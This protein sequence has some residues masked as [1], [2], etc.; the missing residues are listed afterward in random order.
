MVVQLA[1]RP[2]DR[3]CSAHRPGGLCQLGHRTRDND[4][5]PLVSG[6]RLPPEQPLL[7][8]AAGKCHSAPGSLG[9]VPPYPASDSPGVGMLVDHKLTA[10]VRGSVTRCNARPAAEAHCWWQVPLYIHAVRASVTMPI[11][12]RLVACWARG[13]DRCACWSVDGR[14]P[15]GADQGFCSSACWPDHLTAAV[16]GDLGNPA[17]KSSSGWPPVGNLPG[18]A[19]AG[20]TAGAK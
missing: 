14:Q 5:R 3:I 19:H 12:R 4:R 18:C 2:G 11:P 15:P 16:P 6:R 7:P 8:L 10:R 9:P 13:A 20:R 17:K 1:G